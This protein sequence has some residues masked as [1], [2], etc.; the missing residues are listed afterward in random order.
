M[1]SLP[2]IATVPTALSVPPS[3]LAAPVSDLVSTRISPVALT[4][5][6]ANASLANDRSGSAAFQAPA[7]PSPQANSAIATQAANIPANSANASGPSSPFLAQLISQNESENADAQ[8]AVENLFGHFAPALQ[9]NTFLGYSIVKYRPSNAGLPS[10]YILSSTASHNDNAPVASA[11]EAYGK[12]QLR[13]R[14]NAT[15]QKPK[16][17]IAG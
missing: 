10:P 16:L 3:V 15:E 2:S 12:T 6:L 1:F 5:P 17:V 9:Y 8:I 14:S 11:N 13:N 4:A 7:S